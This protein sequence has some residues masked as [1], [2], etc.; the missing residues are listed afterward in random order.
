MA[1]KNFLSTSK[2]VVTVDAKE[3]LRELTVDRPNSRSMAMAL[4]SLMEPKIQERQRELIKEFDSHP[5]TIEL[6]A[7]PK[8]GNTSGTLGGYGN[9]FSFIGFSSGDNPTAVI[10][11]IFKEKIK[12]QVRRVTSSGKYK[13]TFYIPSLDEIYGFTPIPWMTG[14]SWA[15][16]IEEGGLTNLGQYLYSSS[17]FDGSSS[18]TGIQAKN[19]S[20]GVTFRRTPY[21]GKM[22]ANFKKRLLSLDK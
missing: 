20:S 19:R 21:V 10:S 8:A 15:K 4:R 7:G 6:N 3:L 14:K 18:G 1:G 22:I 11:R 12:F 9:L 5:I 17:G 16:S 13:V 2:P